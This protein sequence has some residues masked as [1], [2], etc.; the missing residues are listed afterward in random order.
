[1]SS[2]EKRTARFLLAGGCVHCVAYVALDGNPASVSKTGWGDGVGAERLSGPGAVHRM[3]REAGWRAV[4]P[5]RCL[6]A[7]GETDQLRNTRRR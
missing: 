1:L 5:S 7:Y 4:W 3:T 6:Q 2:A